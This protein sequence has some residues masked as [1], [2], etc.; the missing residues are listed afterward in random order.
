M[1]FY[2]STFLIMKGGEMMKERKNTVI[3][4]L[5]LL[6]AITAGFA[7]YTYAKYTSSLPERSGSASVAKWDFSND[8]TSSTISFNLADTYTA[9][10]LQSGKIAPGTSGTMTILLKST[11]TEVGVNYSLKVGT[12]SGLPANLKFYKDSSYTEEMTPGTTTKTGTLAPKN[13]TGVTETIY[14][15]WL[16]ETTTPANGD[17][18]DT[19]AG[20]AAASLSIPVEIVGTQVQPAVS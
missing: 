10:T 18:D 9:G 5:L 16:Y 13:S 12:V 19:T 11:N 14:W 1:L 6:L 7:A 4:L 2:L 17:A 8:N 15:R 3:V 20:E